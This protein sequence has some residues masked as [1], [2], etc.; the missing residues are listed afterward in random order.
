MTVVAVDDAESD[1]TQLLDRIDAGEE[2]VLSRG[3][4]PVA[5]LVRIEQP[6]GKRKFGALRGILSVGEHAG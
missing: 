3:G 4:R 1:L 5:L 2:I 6:I